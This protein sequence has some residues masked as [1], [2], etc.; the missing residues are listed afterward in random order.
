MDCEA[1]SPF[2]GTQNPPGFRVL[3]NGTGNWHPYFQVFFVIIT[4][5]MKINSIIFNLDM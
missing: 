1:D 4:I 3:G 5:Q 2:P